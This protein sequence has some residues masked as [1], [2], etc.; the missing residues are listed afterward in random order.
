MAV[1]CYG[2]AMSWLRY[3]LIAASL[4]T[5][6]FLA[7]ISMTEEVHAPWFVGGWFFACLLNAGYLVWAGSPVSQP[8]KSRIFR[9]FGLWL[10]AKE[11]ELRN[12]AQVKGN[13]HG[14]RNSF[15]DRG[16]SSGG[17]SRSREIQD[18]RER[19]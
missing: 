17:R 15:T 16:S 5:A 4:E 13:D 2:Q 19:H 8:Q 18:S 3:L 9:L 7:Y 1:S 6:A 11:A 12:R 14:S 10:N